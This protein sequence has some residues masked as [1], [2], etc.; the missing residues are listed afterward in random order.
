MAL[1]LTLKPNEKAIVNGAV[2]VNGERRAA[3]TIVNNA[4][5]LRERDI[6]QPEDATTPARRIYL[7]IMMMLIEQGDRAAH[8]PEFEKRLTQFAAAVSDLEM[9]K[10]CAQIAAKVANDDFY[11]ALRLCR[12]LIEFE[13]EKLDHVA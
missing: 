2:I 5:V 12:E 4:H 11:K 6:L 1:K 13:Q 7:P 9:L 8:Y 3:I 10:T